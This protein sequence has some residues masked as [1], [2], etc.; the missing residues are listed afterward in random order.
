R[1]AR[2]GRSRQHR[3][4]GLAV[5]DHA[6]AVAARVVASWKPAWR[7]SLTWWGD[8]FRPFPRLVAHDSRCSGQIPRP[9]PSPAQDPRGAARVALGAGGERVDGRITPRRLPRAAAVAHC[10]RARWS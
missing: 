9:V 2:P 5:D 6:A 3:L 7:A 1:R 10:L 8:A 4:A